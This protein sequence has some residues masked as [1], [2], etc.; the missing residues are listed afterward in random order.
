M[1]E[2]TRRSLYWSN[3]PVKISACSQARLPLDKLS[4]PISSGLG[5]G[6]M[7]LAQK[8]RPTC[9]FIYSSFIPVRFF[10]SMSALLL[11]HSASDLAVHNTL[12]IK[13]LTLMCHCISILKLSDQERTEE[14]HR[15]AG[16]CSQLGP[17][18]VLQGN[19]PTQASTL[20]ICL[21]RNMYKIWNLLCKD[22]P[23]QSSTT[24]TG[25]IFPV[26]LFHIRTTGLVFR[27]NQNIHSLVRPHRFW[28]LQ[29]CRL[30][31]LSW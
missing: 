3:R 5:H 4:P 1:R 15:L 18:V 30:I 10:F 9:N 24:V 25:P 17:R 26:M 28:V 19:K 27:Q 11:S 7:I 13:S 14:Q 8:P 31:K 29:C 6:A 21:C 20:F 16:G 23:F 22:S 12:Q 2:G